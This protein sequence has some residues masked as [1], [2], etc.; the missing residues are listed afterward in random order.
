MNANSHIRRKHHH[1]G[2]FLLGAVLIGMPTDVHAVCGL[3]DAVGEQVRQAK[4]VS[5]RTGLSFGSCSVCHLATSGGPRNEYGNAINTLLRFSEREDSARQR[6]AGRRVMDIPA[7][8]LSANSP[9]F[10]ELFQQGRLPARSL[11]RQE[12]PLPEVPVR[13]SE[14][15]TVQQA[16]ELV[17]KI[18]AESPFGILQLSKTYEITPAVAEA[19]AEFRGEM[20]ILGL[21]SLSPEVAAALAKSPAANLWLHSVTA[22]TPEAAEALVKLPG[23][24][25]LTSLAELDSVPLAEKLAA[26]PGALSFPYLAKISPEIAAVLAK[27]ER[28]LTLA[29]LTDVSLDVQEKLAETVGSLSLPNLTSLD[30][31]P[32]AKKLAA[33][34]VLLSELKKLSAEHAELLL[35]AKGQGSFFGGIYLSLS[36]VTPEVANVLA[37]TPSAVNLTLLGNGPLPDSILRTLLSSRLR[38]SLRDVEELTASQIRILAEELADRTFRPAVVESASLSLPNLKKLDSALLAETLARANGF[39]FPGVTEI[40]PEAAAALGSLPDGEA[41]GP[42]RKRIVVPS[43]ALSF[44]SL[45]ELPNETARLLMN[46]R[47]V[48]ISLPALEEVSLETVRLMARQTSQL[49]LG[50][51]TLPTE[52][53]GAFAEI[54]TRQPMAGDNISFPYLTDLSPEA[55]RILVTSLNRGFR[56]VPSGFGKFSNSPKLSFGRNLGFATSGFA[57]L[58]PALAVE[59]AKYEG[60]LAI[61]GLGELPAES[62]AA[63]A[64]YP[65][66]RLSMSGPGLERLS[67]EAAASLAKVEAVLKIP[68][69]HLDSKPL[70]ERFARQSSWTLYKLETVSG[71]AAPALT[72]YRPFFD[73]R[74]LKVLDSPEMARRFVEGVT[75]AS[76]ITLP[77][78]SILS[79][80]AAEVLGAGS[81]SMSLGLTVLDSPAVARALSKSRQGVNLSRLRAATPEV[82]AILEESKSIQTPP[83][84]SVYV[85]P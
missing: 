1:L 14:N 3:Y 54:S 82:I 19:L 53:A 37:S 24:L 56:E 42:E 33:T 35:K 50:I 18:E 13:V 22:V 11:A 64:S 2:L 38:I 77:A 72:Q 43:G 58:S 51:P 45:R 62:A 16:R 63:L 10:G 59:L 84:E 9:T 68:L 85:L 81:K 29:G 15:V 20:L 23:H 5:R 55:A 76:S 7:N 80:E 67:P 52:F 65:G 26:R 41:I 57:T 32:L 36:A 39:S 78:L 71:E 12:P 66:P 70:A 46:K 28:S 17:Q 27:N 8:P 69:R 34:F 31:L 6:E 61:E 44:P 73:L 74:A 25:F 40:S 47:W 21:K 75:T 83:L 30:S 48:S 49:T 79:P 4:E 60:N